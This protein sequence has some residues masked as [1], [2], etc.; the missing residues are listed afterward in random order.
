MSRFENVTQLKI[1]HA[2]K[3]SLLFYPL[4][5]LASVVR[6]QPTNQVQLPS[7]RVVAN[8]KTPEGIVG[9]RSV[10]AK[11]LTT[12]TNPLAH[13]RRIN[14]RLLLLPPPRV[15][16]AKLYYSA[17]LHRLKQ[18]QT[19][20]EATTANV[21]IQTAQAMPGSYTA[22]LP[23]S[24]N[25]APTGLLRI[26]VDGRGHP[27]NYTTG[28]PIFYKWLVKLSNNT[29][30]FT[31]VDSFTLPRPLN[32]AIIGDSYASGEGAPVLGG[33]TALWLDQND[34]R[35]R[36]SGE[37]MA[38]QQFK[39]DHP[40]LAIRADLPLFVACSGAG[41]A[42]IVDTKF[43]P[44]F[45][46]RDNS[47]KDPAQLNQ[48]T[49]LLQDKKIEGK[50]DALVVS[51]GGNNFGFATAVEFAFAGDLPG[52]I[53]PLTRNIPRLN[54]VYTAMADR[55]DSLCIP[56]VFAMEYP[57]PTHKPGLP[58]VMTASELSLQSNFGGLPTDIGTFVLSAA[59]ESAYANAQ[60]QALGVCNLLEGTAEL[61]FGNDKHDDCG[62][63]T[64]FQHENYD[65]LKS[66]LACQAS[67]LDNY[68]DVLPTVAEA[69]TA[70]GRIRLMGE[71]I[72]QF[73][74]CID[75][76]DE[77][78]RCMAACIG[79]PGTRVTQSSLFNTF[80]A[81][82]R[83]F[84][85]AHDSILIPMNKVIERIC[86]PK[87][88]WHYVGGTMQASRNHGLCSCGTN[89][90]FNSVLASFSQQKS[91]N[92]TMHMN[93]IGQHAVYVAKLLPSLERHLLPPANRIEQPIGEAC[94]RP[95]APLSSE[96]KSTLDAMEKET[97]QMELTIIQ[98]FKTFRDKYRPAIKVFIDEFDPKRFAAEFMQEDFANMR[99]NRLR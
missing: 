99:R 73:F 3:K 67:N 8:T 14:G 70:F 21:G 50:I 90:Y 13:T 58:S 72:V 31:P 83:D 12:W 4:I 29:N 18:T 64:I 55:I 49:T 94:T 37:F 96:Q 60:N 25:P 76:G 26:E 51:V 87:P 82:Q 10:S 71:V 24:D 80:L 86:Q 84:Q 22:L 74:R 40:E 61:F 39:I 1:L 48:L 42:E 95:V 53:G 11:F 33:E 69:T 59:F 46:D 17:D 35:S 89:R 43:N 79:S 47:E 57:D 36:R 19:L 7:V 15:T 9:E 44:L 92:G 34:H 54:T 38:V 23:H 28:T 6:A 75:Q 78:F 56:H 81:T 20:P 5:L 97:K 77:P 68:I 93:E 66:H 2:M 91:Y 52:N 98:R 85:A 32:I 27:V 16:Q 41:I 30:L 65:H 45:C 63:L 88:N 62:D